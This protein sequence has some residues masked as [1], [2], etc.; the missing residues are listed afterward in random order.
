METKRSYGPIQPT[1]AY[2][3]HL[4]L[5]VHPHSELKKSGYLLT[6]LSAT[7]LERKRRC[8]KCCKGKMKIE[9]HGT[10]ASLTRHLSPYEVLQRER[11]RNRPPQHDVPPRHTSSVVQ[12]NDSR[13]RDSNLSTKI[14]V[15]ESRKGANDDIPELIGASKS[16]KG[17]Q[18][19]ASTKPFFI[20]KY[21]PGHIAYRVNI[22][23]P[24]TSLFH[25]ISSSRAT[26]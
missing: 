3:Q 7:G 17:E 4:H 13:L 25:A 5:F 1:P 11:P 18:E 8:E 20:C 23:Y 21:H 26:K 6:Q 22:F 14:I 12:P 9:H 2:L 16:T 24:C 15:T 10:K 19:S